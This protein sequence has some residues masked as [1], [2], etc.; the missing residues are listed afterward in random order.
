MSGLIPFEGS[1][2]AGHGEYAND[3]G[4]E[5]GLGAR[6]HLGS[7]SGIFLNR[8]LYNPEAGQNIRNYETIYLIELA[9]HSPKANKFIP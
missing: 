3:K 1:G 9:G 7:V 5:K 8:I 6:Y 4:C 2:T